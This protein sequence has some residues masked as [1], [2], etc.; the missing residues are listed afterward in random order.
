MVTSA[1]LREFWGTFLTR[2]G[3]VYKKEELA[4]LA[5][6]FIPG[7][8]DSV[9]TTDVIS[10]C[11]KEY[12]RAQWVVVGKRLRNSVQK[13][14][15]SGEDIEQNLAEKDVDDTG[16][17]TTRDFK[18][19][20]E[21]LSQFGKLTLQDINAICRYFARRPA[22]GE[23]ARDPISL[24]EVM[25]FLG[26]EFVGNL[27]VRLRDAVMY[28]TETGSQDK[29]P[30][31]IADVVRVF[32]RHDSADSTR[33]VKSISRAAVVSDIEGALSELGVFNTLSHEQVRTVLNKAQAKALQANG[34]FSFGSLLRHLGIEYN[35]D[36]S[37]NGEA[38]NVKTS[39]RREELTPEYLL[40]QVIEH[41][42]Q[43]GIAVDEAF[44]HFDSDGNG[45]IS[46]QEFIEAFEQLQIFNN[47]PNW[48]SQ[49]PALVARFDSSGDGDVQLKEFFEFLGV[50]SYSPNIEQRMTKIFAVAIDSGM[51]FDSIYENFDKDG[52]GLMTVTEL[53]DCLKQLGTFNEISKEDVSSCISK[54]S[55][56]D[57]NSVSLADFKVY[58]MQRVKQAQV[59]RKE[60]NNRR[61]IRRF[62]E[63][64]EAAQS[65]GLNAET[66]YQ[67]F[68]KDGDG[69]LTASELTAGL[70]N[71][72]QFQTMER[73]DVENIVA[74]IADSSSNAISLRAFKSFVA[75]NSRVQATTAFE[76][77][78]SPRG[79]TEEGVVP[80]FISLMDAARAKGLSPEKL[81]CHFDRDGN[82]SLSKS[83][84]SIGLRNLAQFKSLTSSDIQ[85]ILHELDNDDSGS[86]SLDEF[87]SFL[88]RA[89]GSN[90]RYES[91]KGRAVEKF[92]RLMEVSKSKG[93]STEKIFRHFDKDNSGTLTSAEF[94]AALKNLPQF[95]T[96]TTEDFVDITNAL[97]GDGNGTV[98][99]SEL[100]AFVS[101]VANYSAGLD[102]FSARVQKLFRTATSKGVSLEK[103]FGHLDKNGNGIFDSRELED[104]LLKTK[105]FN[106]L[107]EKDI[108][109]IMDT[110]DM[111]HDGNVTFDEFK[112]FVLYGVTEDS[113]P[114]PRRPDLDSAL[115]RQ[116]DT[117]EMLLRHLRRISE[118]DG[119]I[120]G[121][122][123]FLDR[124]EDGEISL[125]SFMKLLRREGVLDTMKEGDIL[126][127]L[128][129][130]LLTS[131][132]RDENDKAAARE[133]KGEDSYSSESKGS[134]ERSQRHGE[135]NVS[136][137]I[138][139][140]P[141]MHMLDGNN[142]DG[143]S[144]TDAA[145]DARTQAE[146]E[147]LVLRALPEYDFSNDPEIRALEK[148]L[149]GVGHALARRGLDVE[150]LFKKY[151]SLGEGT[152]RRTEFLEVL[153][154]MGLYI[155]EK[156][157]ALEAA[158]GGAEEEKSLQARQVARIKGPGAS[159]EQSIRAARKYVM[160]AGDVNRGGSANQFQVS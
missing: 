101:P 1:D 95:K 51:T 52:D 4:V 158:A 152:I 85:T 24:R 98:S 120:A 68:D 87:K 72:P 114:G 84:L 15:L 107:S 104:A 115:K 60:R 123:A 33:G 55:R 145:G 103:L 125:N 118:P 75:E 106:D 35:G 3:V 102:T 134:H 13:A 30:R 153:S 57:S 21:A 90:G 113:G 61:N 144:S 53:Y 92:R 126:D 146:Q 31:A 67:H 116:G 82:G 46:G 88:N 156:G 42:T 130:A 78:A 149:R 132:Q 22:D 37:D 66:I 97:D 128:K 150:G 80:K 25:A 94:V 157:K 11:K 129:P 6:K 83:E 77:K 137:S 141:L 64:M 58:F 89:K 81:F 119:G 73:G 5:N 45:S 38:D 36:S 138:R 12:D 74:F 127:W 135:G 71:L 139:V 27:N 18:F 32:R 76:P 59:E 110:L 112:N 109:R 117:R 47:I 39:T 86:V 17:I 19:F 124:D 151:D 121:L 160:S 14:S 122:L 155:L 9:K 154:S 62:I 7:D 41:T 48:K 63:L 100:E 10:F 56:T 93:L 50:K 131:H 133:E 70:S 108:R 54:F 43:H 159:S 143:G 140:V 147:S 26:K 79:V 28:A 34:K 44:R 136:S 105:A 8:A 29:V 65:K 20:L 23:P 69:C 40:R 16:F 96:M 91:S 148:K 99:M 111:N 49:I 2:Y 142:P